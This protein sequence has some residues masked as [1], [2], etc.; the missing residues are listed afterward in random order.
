MQFIGYILL[1]LVASGTLET[2]PGATATADS[3]RDLT[4]AE[5]ARV[6]NFVFEGKTRLAI[7][8]LRNVAD[9]CGGQ[10]FYL[11][12]KTRVDRELLTI[13]DENK[14]QVRADADPIHLDLERVIAICSQRMDDGDKDPRL[15]LYRGLAWMSK[16]HLH[17]F[18][19]RFWRAGRDAK[20][21]KSD[22][23]TYLEAHPE[24]PLA[25]GT[26]GVFLYFA[27][28]IPSIFK[29]V[30]KLLFM[31]TGDREKGLR[32]IQHAAHHPSFLQPEF[33]GVL[34]TIHLLFE[35]RF[36]D[37]MEE[38]IALIERY[39]ANPRFAMPMA[40]MLP[41]DPER[42]GQ[43]AALVDATIGRLQDLP[44]DEPERYPLTLLVFLSTYANRFFVPPETAMAQLRRIADDNPE[45]PDW[46]GGYAAFELGRL[47][48]SVGMANDARTVFNW[49]GHN[50]RVS[51]LH[52]DAERL[53]RA[54]RDSDRSANVPKSVWPT[55]IYFGSTDD[56]N[57]AIED[58]TATA[59]TPPSD[60]YLAE[61]YLI[62]GNL[63]AA[64]AAYLNVVESQVDPWNKEF[65]ML[66]S[67][68][69]AEIHGARGDY[70]GASRWLGTAMDYYQK[71]FLID[72]LLQGRRRFYDQLRKGKT[73]AAPRLLTSVP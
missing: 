71:E 26:M 32:Y 43:N 66:A 2:A 50:Q 3:T 34:G 46:V 63:D 67:S 16:S 39:P 1:V 73:T 31:P 64:L 5:A 56:R 9:N 36:E 7:D 25:M 28:T 54:L 18:A 20:R 52:D 33:E 48:A 22:L 14:D 6:M 44:P 41:F 65:Q 70:D 35:G 29:Y 42:A 60:F 37:G 12:V 15:R 53:S 45:H 21:G 11:L 69:I 19:R 13:D 23:E 59:S 27:D 38:T 17:S 40:L 4:P 58:L 47:L 61:A 62:A 72:W 49:V 24:D 68:R 10:P 30:A 51:Y 55:E 8:Y 57:N